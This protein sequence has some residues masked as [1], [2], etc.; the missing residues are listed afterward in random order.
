MR[1]ND[2]PMSSPQRWQSYSTRTKKYGQTHP[3]KGRNPEAVTALAPTP[4]YPLQ[5]TVPVN[6]NEDTL[7]V[8]VFL[9]ALA[10]KGAENINRV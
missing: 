1:A 9:Q 2:P 6:C 3:D 5:T 8:H 4:G 7:C 10:H